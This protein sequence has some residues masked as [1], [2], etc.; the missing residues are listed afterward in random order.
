MKEEEIGLALA[1]VRRRLAAAGVAEPALEARVLLQEALRLPAA[2]LLA[3]LREPFPEAARARLAELIRRRVHREP[4]AYL[5]GQRE[6]FGLE[7]RVDSR[8][9]I[10]RPE[11]ELLVELALHATARLRKT[12]KALHLVD[13]GT[14]SGAIAIALATRLPSDFVT[15]ID[16]SPAALAVAAEN[17]RRHHVD[18]RV[19]VVAGD[20]L[21][22]LASSVDLIVANLP[23]IP[24]V[25]VERLQ[26]EV[27]DHEPRLALDGGANGLHLYQRLI[28]QASA[29]LDRP[30]ALLFE[31]G[32]GQAD[33][34]SQLARAAF[35]GA[36]IRRHRDLAGIE[37]VIEIEA[38]V[39]SN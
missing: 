24:S 9:L 22:P 32:A 4:L 37:R 30:G 18:E 28:G 21:A 23:Y 34:A 10:P 2:M 19:A 27:R 14:G 35:P 29:C 16:C 6:F 13:V 3:R 36:I 8:V 15:A 5:I 38:R 1:D 17:V 33:A 11:T 31:I 25:E 20:L 7:L 12:D 39:H 26:P